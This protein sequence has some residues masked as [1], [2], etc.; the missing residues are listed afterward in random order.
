MLHIAGLT[1]GYWR[2]EGGM[3]SQSPQG[4]FQVHELSYIQM[5]L[6]LCVEIF[7]RA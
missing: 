2:G 4:S 3:V 7:N 5:I 6:S 1:K